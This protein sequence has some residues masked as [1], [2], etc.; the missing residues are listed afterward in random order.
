[1][2]TAIAE[3]AA[4]GLPPRFP[5]VG[6]EAVLGIE[7]NPYAAELAR[8]SVWIGHIQWARGNGYPAPQDPVLR[9]LGTIECRDAVLAAD[10][11]GRPVPAA[12]PAADAIVGNP[13]FIGGKALRRSLGDAYVDRLFAAYAGRVP[14][15]ADFVTYWFDNVRDALAAGPAHRAGLVITNSIRGGANR[16]VLERATRAAPIAEAW[17]DEPWTLDG[18]AVRVSLVCFARA[19]T[20]PA[21]LDGREVAGVFADLTAGGADLTRAARLPANAGVCFM[22][23]TK[24]GPFDVDGATARAW[25]R[26]PPNANGRLNSDVVR[27]WRNGLHVTRRPA[28]AWV[29]DFGATR[30]EAEA[31]W[32]ASPFAYAAAEVRPTRD[33]ANRDPALRAWWRHGRPR[34]EMRAAL[35]GLPRYIVTPSVAK[36]RVFAW[37]DAA[38]LPD[39][40]LLVF[41]RADDAFFGLLHSRFHEAW[42]LR[43]GTSLEDRPRYTP[44]TSF[45]T[46]P[47][48]DGLTPDLPAAA[49]AADP[50]VA[51]I[52]AAAR[53]LDEARERWLNPPELVRREPEVAPGLPVR[54]VPVDAAAAAALAKRTLT[55]LYNTRGTPAGAWLDNLH[56]ALDA[57]VAAAYGWPADLPT[58][59]ALARL[60]ALNI[61]QA[62]A[63]TGARKAGCPP[64][65]AVA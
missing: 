5:E 1:L 53:A 20:G 57:A 60:L 29:V 40:Q 49:W 55:A 17:S 51:A 42:A 59:E 16:E 21:R 34:P 65:S 2:I 8:V 9:R 26:E 33:P 63:G 30:N 12:W 45:E 64:S 44:T 4:L 13:P 54:L 11:V 19:H 10:G 25:L 46:F 3:A 23:T 7:L 14:A 56:A 47:F 24:V 31:A 22:G 35:A 15:E 36:H 32:Y 58:D 27:P 43:L 6:P 62:D 37:L 61:A 38:V 41:A 39:H 48:P 28:D 50:R 52:A 18:A